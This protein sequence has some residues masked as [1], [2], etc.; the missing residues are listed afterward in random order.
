MKQAIGRL[1]FRFVYQQYLFSAC[2]SL[3]LFLKQ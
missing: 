3:L 2:T 1:F